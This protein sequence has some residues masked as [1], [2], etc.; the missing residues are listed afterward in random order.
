MT[1]LKGKNPGLVSK[2]VDDSHNR[3]LSDSS[4]GEVFN[5]NRLLSMNWVSERSQSVRCRL[6][7]SSVT[8]II[9]INGTGSN[10][11]TVP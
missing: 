10:P 8:F 11:I 2:R 7:M 1:S 9:M 5:G 4:Q 6:P 3:L